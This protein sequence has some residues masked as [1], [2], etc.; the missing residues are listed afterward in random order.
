MNDEK[1]DKNFN[2]ITLKGQREAMEAYRA[3]NQGKNNI[4]RVR[5]EG[6]EQLD[7]VHR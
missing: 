7:E 3:D 1:T 2:K 4:T 5:V 6:E